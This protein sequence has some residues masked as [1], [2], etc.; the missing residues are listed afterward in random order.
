MVISSNY[1]KFEGKRHEVHQISVGCLI[2]QHFTLFQNFIYASGPSTITR[3]PFPRTFT[4]SSALNPVT[5]HSKISL[6]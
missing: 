6:S 1:S 3:T 2:T 5:A 4:A